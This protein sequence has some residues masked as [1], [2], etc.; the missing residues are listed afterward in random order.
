MATKKPA[1][2]STTEEDG[3]ITINLPGQELAAYHFQEPLGRHLSAIE[4]YQTANPDSTEI[5]TMAFLMSQLEAEGLPMSHFLDLP[6]KLFKFISAEL[7]E[8]FRTEDL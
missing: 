1:Y 2:T 4:K 7:N 5:D 8:F 6:L 3:S